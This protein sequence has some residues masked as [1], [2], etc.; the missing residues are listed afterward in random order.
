MSASDVIHH[1][2]EPG[3]SFTACG[4]WAAKNLPSRDGMHDKTQYTTKVTCNICISKIERAKKEHK[5][6]GGSK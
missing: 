2:V 6:E 5:L 3:K 4:N 1:Y